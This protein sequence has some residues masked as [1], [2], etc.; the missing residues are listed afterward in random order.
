M[1]GIGGLLPG[2]QV[3][4]RVPAIVQCGRQIVIVADMAEGAS[5]VGMA[6]GQRE[7]GRAV[8]E[9]G[10]QPG[11]KRMACL[12]VGGELCGNVVGIRGFL[13]I[14]QVAGRAGR[15]KPKVIPDGRILMALIALQDGMR[16]QQWKSV[17]VLRNRLDRYLPSE[18]G[19]ALGAVLAELSA[20]N[21]GVTIGA[22]LAHVGEYR[23]GVA[24]RAGYFFVH[25]AKRVP[26]GVVVEFWNGAN[27]RPTG[28]GVAIFAGNVKRPMRTSAR[29]PLGGCGHDNG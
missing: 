24:S 2:C 27:G 23:L 20:V 17:E 25:A 9:F 18:D 1:Y 3:A 8:V 6:L 15:R 16:A 21:V 26:R 12:A 5:H 22:V 7:T 13:K 19:M 14:C 28:V 10:V 11:V 4:S 29:L